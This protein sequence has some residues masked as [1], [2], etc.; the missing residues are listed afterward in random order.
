MTD[1]SWVT[2]EM[3]DSALRKAAEGED[4]WTIPGVYEILSEHFNNAALEI[5]EREREEG[6]DNCGGCGHPAALCACI[7][8]DD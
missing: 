3:F 4:L 1:Y 2:N 5:L 6:T 7:P 8:L